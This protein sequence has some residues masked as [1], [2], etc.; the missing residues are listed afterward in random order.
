MNFVLTYKPFGAFAILIEWPSRIDNDII[1]DII[2]FEKMIASNPLILDSIIAYN[3][4]TILY[5]EL[6]VYKST[7]LQL[8]E[9]YKSKRFSEKKSQKLWKIPVCY[10]ESFALDLEEM[11][12]NK[13]TFKQEIIDLHSAP[14]YSIYF[15]GFQPGF[16]YLGGLN[17]KL[18]T[19]RKSN[20]R[21]RIEKGSVGIGGEQ[22]GVYPSNS[23][24]GWNIIGK[25]PIDFFN[26]NV[27][28]S[29]FAN[30]GDKI[31]F[32]QVTIDTFYTIQKE[33]EKGTY[34]LKSKLL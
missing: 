20:P 4:L 19:P 13:K 1:Q 16:L 33:I 23:S 27:S 3:S 9:L 31:Q 34:Q 18:H 8:K 30:P 11:A 10:D 29:C 7:V 22:T 5:K 21:L 14:I 28:P 26:V 32:Q 25:S 12:T 6:K 2:N 15:I 24:G 17:P